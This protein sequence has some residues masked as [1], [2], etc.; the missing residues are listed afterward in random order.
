MQSFGYSLLRYAR[1]LVDEYEAS[2]PA[3]NLAVLQT[4]RQ[5]TAFLNPRLYRGI[6][7]EPLQPFPSLDPL[8]LDAPES[9][10]WLASN[11][12]ARIRFRELQGELEDDLDLNLDCV[13]RLED[14]REIHSLL[15]DRHEYEI[16]LLERDASGSAPLLLGYDIGYWVGDHY[17]LICDSLVTPTWHPPQ[18]EDFAEL[19][20]YARGLNEHVLFPDRTSAEAFREFYRSRD[21]AETESEPGEFCIIRVS[22]APP[23]G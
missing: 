13:D 4:L 7:R 11:R 18:P 9:E 15:E 23:A 19:A 10:E 17:S 1:A 12:A 3:Q 14:A 16:I 6:C 20:A 2:V 8:F 21:W 22:A 5:A